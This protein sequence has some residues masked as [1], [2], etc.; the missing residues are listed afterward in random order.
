MNPSP[1]P[2]QPYSRHLR[3][4]RRRPGGPDGRP[5]RPGGD[6]GAAGSLGRP[7]CPGGNFM[8]L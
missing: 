7:G 6:R 5:R 3:G 4:H 1:L 2:P 8:L